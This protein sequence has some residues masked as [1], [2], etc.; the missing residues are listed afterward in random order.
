MNALLQLTDASLI[1]I[2]KM[3][4]PLLVLQVILQ[5]YCIVKII[6][7]RTRNMNQLIWIGIVLIFNIFGPIAFLIF[8]INKGHEND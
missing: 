3:V 7:Q 1:E 6:K 4:W 8:G 2:L 5:V